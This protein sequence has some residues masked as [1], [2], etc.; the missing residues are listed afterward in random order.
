MSAKIL[1]SSTVEIL[2]SAGNVRVP[3]RTKHHELVLV[4]DGG[5]ELRRFSFEDF[6]PNCAHCV[7]RLGQF[8]NGIEEEDILITAP[9]P[10]GIQ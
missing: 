4:G 1:D 5:E 9:P 3:S 2:G 8:L 10:R 6:D 7:E